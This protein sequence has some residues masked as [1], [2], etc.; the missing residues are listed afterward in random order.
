MRRAAVLPVLVACV[1]SACSGSAQGPQVPRAAARPLRVMSINL[2]ADQLVL[3]LLP[4][5][6]IA[7]VTWMAHD[8]DGSLMAPAAAGVPENHGFAED[9]ARQRP[10]L[11]IAGR[12][13]APATRALLKK[14]GYPLLEIDEASSFDDIRRVTRE[15]AHAVGEE[16][17]GEALI[18]RMDGQLAELARDRAPPLR[19]VAWDGAGFGA[20][21][22]SLYDTLLGAA[23]AVNVA[24]DQPVGGLG[25]PDVEILLRTAPTLL[26]KGAGMGEAPGLRRNIERHAL[27]R[28]YW[29][30]AR[31]I[32]IRQAAYV[33]GTPMVAGAALELRDK[34]RAAAARVH[35]PLPFAQENAL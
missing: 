34:L 16:A 6:R 35:E 4:R 9:V 33:C 23:G 27:V 3:A 18:T 31:T 24:D 10:D 1:L 20:G 32:T 5:D 12:F 14:L 2:C 30:G 8:P 17:R 26:V 11:V 25:R 28:R 7:S 19:V 22:G 13:A 15:V 21:K 29:D